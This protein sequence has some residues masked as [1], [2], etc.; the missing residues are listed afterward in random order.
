VTEQ[1][2]APSGVDVLTPSIARIYDYHLGGT[3]NYPSDRDAAE[4]VT[5]QLPTF[6][7]ILRENR[8]FLRRCARYLAEQGVTYFL[9]L[10]SGIPTVDNVHEIVQEVNPSARVVYVDNDAVA[11]AH[12]KEI[13]SGN[14]RAAAVRADL[15]DPESVLA[16]P[17]VARL[18]LLEL[19]EPIAVILSAV[20][21]FI[22]DDAEA[23]A[24]VA[25]YRD[26][27]PPGSY[28]A[29]SHGAATPQEERVQQAAETYSRTVADFKLRSLAQ[30]E[31]LLTGFELVEPGAVHCSEWHPDAAQP[32]AGAPLPQI[33]AL[34]RKPTA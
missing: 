22:P 1:P 8:A 25:A 24:L 10:G 16:D 20:L 7:A 32:A 23:A 11:I 34:G 5:R 21:H 3:H 6:P 30:L 26:A 12:S 13:L 28:M 33:C 18:L 27:L 9:D 4:E 17:D 14:E 31:A 2:P 19:G 29:I 15:R